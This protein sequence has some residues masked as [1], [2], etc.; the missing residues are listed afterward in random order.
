MKKIIT[1]V[2]L[3]SLLQVSFAKESIELVEKI[4]KAHKL[5]PEQTEKVKT[6]LMTGGDNLMSRNVFT[7]DPNEFAG[8]ANAM[9]P[10]TRAECIKKVID[11]GLL[12][13]N[14][15]FE[16]ICGAPWMSPLPGPDGDITK[17]KSCIDQFEYPNIPCEYPLIW[18]TIVDA[19]NICKAEGKRLCRSFE[20]EA[21][22][23]GSIDTRP[24][25]A[26]YGYGNKEAHNNARE[27]VYAFNWQEKYKDKK[28]KAYELCSIYH[29]DDKEFTPGI[30][31]PRKIYADNGER[32]GCNKDSER[33]MTATCGGTTWPAGFKFDCRSKYDVF[34]MHGN[35]AEQV[36]LPNDKA[37]LEGNGNSVIPERKGIWFVRPTSRKH[38]CR[39]RQGNDHS[40]L[41]MRFFQEGFRCCKNAAN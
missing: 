8:P 12:V 32:R 4:S 11:T 13:Q 3:S 33:T 26:H 36:W 10:A 6:I 16:K 38:D 25:A 22:C 37:T 1:L 19:Q 21:G 9:H 24:N 31:D 2:T 29:P 20:W 27:V 39:V 15:E 5:T 28:D 17:A 14:P 35:L 40:A 41:G 18:S 30:G 34:E 23:A 7:E